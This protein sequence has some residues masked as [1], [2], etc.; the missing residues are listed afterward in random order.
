MFHFYSPRFQEEWDGN[1]EQCKFHLRLAK[2]TWNFKLK[3][4]DE[5]ITWNFNVTLK[6][7]LLLSR[8]KILTRYTKFKFQLG[9]KIA[10]KSVPGYLS[11]LIFKQIIKVLKD[12]YFTK[13]FFKA[14]SGWCS[15]STYLVFRRNGNVTF[16]NVNVISG[17]LN[18]IEFSTRYTGLKFLHVIAM[19][20]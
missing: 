5:I 13:I 20:F 14:I 16:N 10:L 11:H 19:S 9:L 12:C 17:E 15:I 8:D 1:N 2:P 7:N 4:R 18:R 6:S 3:Y